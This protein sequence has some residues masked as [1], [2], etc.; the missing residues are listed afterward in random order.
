MAAAIEAYHKVCAD[1]QR[2]RAGDRRRTTTSWPVSTSSPRS[3]IPAPA[4][5]C[6]ARPATTVML[7]SRAG[8]AR[9][10][11]LRASGRSR[12]SI[13]VVRSICSLFSALRSQV[14]VGRLIAVVGRQG[15]RRGLDRR[16]QCRLGDRA[17]PRAR[18]GGRRSRPRLRHRR[19]STTTRIRP[20]GIADAVFSPD[21]VGQRVHGPP[22]RRSAADHLSLLAAPATLDRVYD[23]GADAFDAVFDTM[24]MR[25]RPASCWTCRINGPPGP[26]APWSAPTTS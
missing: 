19:A 7:I 4:W 2:D 5:S 11:R 20:Q 17:R 8:A 26:S 21:R 12:C 18:F 6:S 13:D 15:R 9:R 25:P 3:A 22:A 23:F 1:A 24:R 16:A 10:Q 14:S